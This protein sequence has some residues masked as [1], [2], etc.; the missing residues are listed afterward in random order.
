MK[1][2]MVP[3]FSGGIGLL[4]LMIGIW[5]M[6]VSKCKLTNTLERRITVIV[7]CL[8]IILGISMDGFLLVLPLPLYWEIM[9]PL[10]YL[11]AVFLFLGSGA[12]NL[13]YRRNLTVDPLEG[14]AITIQA[15]VSI[16]LGVLVFVVFT[17]IGQ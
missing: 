17:L 4:F 6:F 7:A 9:R 10:V 16:A 5:Y 12:Y 11:V 3:W 8:C 1:L 2:A 15:W 13:I 14:K